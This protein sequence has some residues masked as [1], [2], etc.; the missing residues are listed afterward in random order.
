MVL[1]Y[2]Y[3][4]H[5]GFYSKRFQKKKIYTTPCFIPMRAYFYDIKILLLRTGMIFKS[6]GG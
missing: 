3:I 4:K 1:T 2:W 5:A 6:A